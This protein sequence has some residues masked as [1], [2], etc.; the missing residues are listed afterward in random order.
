MLWFFDMRL[1]FL[2][3]QVSYGLALSIALNFKSPWDLATA[4]HATLKRKLKLDDQRAKKLHEHF[5]AKF[6]PDMTS[7][8]A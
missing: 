1:F 8:T 4:A 5:R 2:F 6:R 3:L 7:V